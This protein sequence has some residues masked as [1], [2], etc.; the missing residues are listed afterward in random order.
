MI[1]ERRLAIR[2]ALNNDAGKPFM[3]I[4]LTPWLCFARVNI[5]GRT[6]LVPGASLCSATLHGQAALKRGK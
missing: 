6:R 5:A 2:S 4:I 1:A 3:E